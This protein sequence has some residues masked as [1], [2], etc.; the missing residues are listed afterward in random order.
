MLDREEVERLLALLAK[1]TPGEWRRGYGNDVGSN[2][3]YYIEWQEAGPAQIHGGN[4]DADADLI[5]A[6][7]HALPELL[8]LWL[9]VQDAPV[10]TFAVDAAHDHRGLHLRDA[11]PEV[12]LLQGQRVRILPEQAKGAE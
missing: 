4:Q 1:A 11:D 5:A 7:H 10:A 9:A 6:M 8:R 3:G 12:L 2:D